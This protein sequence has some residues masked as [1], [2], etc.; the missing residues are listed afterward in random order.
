MHSVQSGSSPSHSHSTAG[1]SPTGSETSASKRHTFTHLTYS[2]HHLIDIGKETIKIAENGEY[3]NDKG[4][5]VHIKK[6][7]DWAGDNCIHYSHEFDFDEA[8]KKFEE[9]LSKHGNVEKIQEDKEVN[10][11]GG[12]P[13]APQS[14][15]GPRRFHRTSFLV[16]SASWLEA[17]SELLNAEEKA[18]QTDNKSSKEPIHYRVGV[19]NSASSTTP[20]GRFLKGTVSQED[21]LCRA[22]LLYACI[23]QPKFQSEGRFYGKN[24]SMRY[25]SSN[26]VIFSP[27]VPV[28]REDT[29]E[30]KLLDAYHKVSFVTI[31]APNAFTTSTATGKEYND[32]EAED[33]LKKLS[34]HSRNVS[35]ISLSKMGNSD[36]DA[37]TP[38]QAFERKWNELRSSVS[39]RIHRALAAFALGNCVDLVL[40]AFG[41]GVHGND[42]SMVASVFR[43]MLT[44]PHQFGGRFRTVVFAIP[45]SRKQNYQAF[46]EFFNLCTRN[47]PSKFVAKPT[48]NRRETVQ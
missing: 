35:E 2:R 24:R 3:T 13:R 14:T 17:A 41:C 22:S 1:N 18:I 21:C 48:L 6:D 19:L 42:P 4:E 29:V 9:E 43:E 38:E 26:C 36:E 20:G 10:N 27:D 11:F 25:G 40:P 47:V 37:E 23:S 46:A 12:I 5:V 45:P 34:V 31:P 16:V 28:I 30:G 33:R 7:L 32:V 15:D 44:D 39:D 8:M